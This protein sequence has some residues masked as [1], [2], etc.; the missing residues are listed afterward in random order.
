MIHHSLF[1]LHLRQRRVARVME[2]NPSAWEGACAKNISQK[3]KKG[4]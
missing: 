2:N 1:I 3:N 4:Y